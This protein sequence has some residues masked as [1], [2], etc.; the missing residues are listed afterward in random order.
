MCRA[1]DVRAWAAHPSATQRSRGRFCNGYMPA[2]LGC[3]MRGAAC[4]ILL[5]AAQACPHEL[6]AQDKASSTS[7]SCL[8]PAPPPLLCLQGSV[9]QCGLI[10]LSSILFWA[11][12]SGEG[13]GGA[14]GYIA[15]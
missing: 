3:T 1:P 9:L 5:S 7:D 13:S 2:L 8:P 10:L 11:F 4:P 12:R 14:Y 6:A 15:H